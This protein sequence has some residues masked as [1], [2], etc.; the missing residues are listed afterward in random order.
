VDIASQLTTSAC[1]AKI[2]EITIGNWKR[3]FFEAGSGCGRLACRQAE[4]LTRA[5]STQP[6]LLDLATPDIA[7]RWKDLPL[8][9]QRAVI[10]ALIAAEILPASGKG[11]AY[12]F[13]PESVKITWRK[14]G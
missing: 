10:D 3:Q 13:N 9:R 1:R 11:G 14:Q 7:E 5:S 12:Q 4:A 8:A 6:D 2:S